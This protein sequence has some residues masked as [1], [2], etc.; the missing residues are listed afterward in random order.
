MRAA[1][2]L[3]VV[4]VRLVPELNSRLSSVRFVLLF[5]HT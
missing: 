2:I 4:G 3:A 5:K 1:A